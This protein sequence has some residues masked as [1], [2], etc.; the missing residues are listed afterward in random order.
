M[1]TRPH[2]VAQGRKAMMDRAVVPQSSSL[3]AQFEI[4][5]HNGSRF[6]AVS[7]GHD[8]LVM[9]WLLA[10]EMFYVQLKIAETKDNNL[11]PMVDGE[12]IPDVGEEDIDVQQL[13]RSVRLT[14]Q[15]LARQEETVEYPSVMESLF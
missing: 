6:E 9:A 13:P 10:I 5:A 2:L 7:G 4:F 3:I 15:A 1:R 14:E 8:D 11:L 12:F